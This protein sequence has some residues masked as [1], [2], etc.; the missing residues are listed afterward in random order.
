MKGNTQRLAATARLGTALA[1]ALAA[2]VY[3]A[4]SLACSSAA[5]PS[6]VGN[7]QVSSGGETDSWFFNSDGTCGEVIMTSNGAG[8]A[9]ECESNCRYTYSG[10]TLTVTSTTDVGDAGAS[11][12]ISTTYSASLSSDT[13]TLSEPDAGVAPEQLTRVD[14]NGS[15]SCP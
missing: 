3:F 5:G 1:V 10:G 9:S 14:S 7:W 4:Q 6:L 13:L 11:V 8:T 2:G 15:T 12:S